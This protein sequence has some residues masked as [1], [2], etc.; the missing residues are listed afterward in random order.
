MGQDIS[1]HTAEWK[2][3]HAGGKQSR[4]KS[5]DIDRYTLQC[6]GFLLLYTLAE[7]VAQVPPE[8]RS[9]TITNK[10]TE[11][12]VHILANTLAEVKPKTL[13][14]KLTDVKAGNLDEMRYNAK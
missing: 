7:R 3:G 2:G 11:A 13:S 4:G 14:D 10:K 6:E 9:D 12:I 1:R 5:R 8:T